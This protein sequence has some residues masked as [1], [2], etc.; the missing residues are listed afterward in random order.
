MAGT[1]FL[2]V[3]VKAKMAHDVA[4]GMSYL[5]S[6]STHPII[7]SD[8]KLHNI[9]VGDHFN[10]KVGLVLQKLCSH[11]IIRLESSQR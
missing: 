2:P 5:H 1:G 7:H 9:L 10:A 8:L 11:P 4:S 6:L 3:L